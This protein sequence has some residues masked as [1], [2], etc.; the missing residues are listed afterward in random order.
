MAAITQKRILRHKI[1]FTL[2]K[3]LRTIHQANLEQ[4]A[5]LKAIIDFSIDFKKRFSKLASIAAYLY[6][7]PDEFSAKLERDAFQVMA[8]CF[9]VQ[10]SCTGYL[11]EK[12]ISDGGL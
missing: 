8:L 4:V 11:L 6:F 5:S 3:F 1:Q 12:R 2:T 10:P 9:V 7:S